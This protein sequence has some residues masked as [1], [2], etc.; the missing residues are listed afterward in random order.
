MVETLD[1]SAVHRMRMYRKNRL[2][3]MM[4]KLDIPNLLIYDP[5]SIR[6]VTDS[7]N[8]QV[9]AL[10]HDCRY[11]FVGADG[12]C[13]LFDW[14]AGHEAYHG[15]L[16]TVDAVHV[17]QPVGFMSDGTEN[18]DASLATWANQIE[19][20]VR[21]SSPDDLRIGIDRMTPFQALAL[22]ARGIRVVDGQPAIY[23]A[24]AVKGPEE[25]A[26]QR[27]S[28]KA[29]HD[30][31]ERMFAAT[32]PGVTESDIWAHLHAANIEWEGEWINSR[33]LLSGP[34]TNPWSQETGLRV[35]RPGDIIGCD[36]DLVGPYGYAHD[37]SRTWIAS[38]RPTD[39]QRRLYALCHE[40]VHR[41]MALLKPG[42][43][44]MELTRTS[45]N[46]PPEFARQNFSTVYHGLGLENEWPIIKSSDKLD[47][48]GAY[49]GGYDGV[50]ERGMTLCIESY[51]GEVGGP[52]GVKLE[53]MVV[54][55]ETG[56]EP[57]SLT[58]YEESWL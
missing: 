34:K 16:E 40:H 6:Y 4:Q 10:N 31:F 47:V 37:I 13:E 57:L 51:A 30:G 27:I 23:R 43:T 50:I 55:T 5:V 25:L 18:F 14:V 58:P 15:H 49:G 54:I 2:M 42:V 24:R 39:R 20:L 53:E 38:G 33:F 45:F 44:F 56:A 1:A 12:T 35:I 28:A 8:V 52:D 22:E 48:P 7:R 3:A 9:Y 32:R 46:Y 11:L 29:C 26:A 17:A 36:S 41:N 19:S 21:R